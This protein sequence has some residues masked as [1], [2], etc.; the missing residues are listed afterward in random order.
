MLAILKY[1]LICGL[2][3]GWASLLLKPPSKEKPPA[4]QLYEVEIRAREE[5]LK[6]ISE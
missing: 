6:K 2:S 1:L 5:V 4:E 3:A